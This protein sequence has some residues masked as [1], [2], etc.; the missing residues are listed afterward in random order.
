MSQVFKVA[1]PGY[2]AQTD[3]NPNH[4]SL[5]V[6]PL[7]DYVLIKEF[8]RG[9]IVVADG[10]DGTVDHSLGYVPFVSCWFKKSTEAFYRWANDS[11]FI[12]VTVHPTTSQVKFHNGLGGGVS[13]T[14]FYYIFYDNLT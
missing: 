8:A 10:A 14:F 12:A 4:F 6:D 1:L 9:S 11:Q 7:V 3:T 2:N 13:V 5:Y